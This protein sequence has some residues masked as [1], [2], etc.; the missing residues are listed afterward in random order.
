[1]LGPDIHTPRRQFAPALVYP[2]LQT[3]SQVALAQTAVPFCGAAWQVVS[4]DAYE[5]A[6]PLQLPI[7]E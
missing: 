3:K 4:I 7:D 1:M 5:Q 6:P 2:L